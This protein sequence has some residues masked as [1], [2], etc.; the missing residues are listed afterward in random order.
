MARTGR[1]GRGRAEAAKVELAT[2]APAVDLPD[3][4]DASPAITNVVELPVPWDGCGDSRWRRGCA[5]SVG[6]SGGGK[7]IN[8]ADCVPIPISAVPLS[9][10]TGG[11]C[12]HLTPGSSLALRCGLQIPVL[13]LGTRQLKPGSECRDTVRAAL[14]CGYRLID[15][16]STYGNEEDVG[17]GIR[18]AGLQRED[19]FIVTKLAPS[20]HGDLEDVEEALQA[21]LQRLGTTYIDLYLIQSP[22]GGSV[23]STWA[24]ML[25][26]R[27]RG[28]ARVVGVSNFGIAHLQGL[29]GV[30][31]E[32]PEVNQ[33]ELHFGLQQRSLA[34]YC[35][36]MGIVV[37]AAC[38]LARGRLFSGQTS[39]GGLAA[40][41]GR[42]EAELA[43]RWCLQRGYVAIPKT[44][45]ASR[46]EVNAPFGFS[47][48]AAEMTEIDS[49]DRG[50]AASPATK[51]IQLPWE[52]AVHEISEV[53]DGDAGTDN[54][55]RRRRRRRRP[56]GKGKGKA[57][58]RGSGGSSTANQTGTS[59]GNAATRQAAV[60]FGLS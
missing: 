17:N 20:D 22:K 44:K 56:K 50:V 29:S 46:V 2:P 16:A 42:T 28:L 38:P 5:G 23:I 7:V 37:M 35:R 45:D 26:I 27:S 41:R 19:V 31:L 43:L 33:I 53:S 11:T 39:L 8:A 14:R 25:E 40:K 54:V 24:A 10:E 59:S 32:P 18:A 36:T 60:L 48:S 49:L 4:G 57:Q 15:T 6:V 47:L 51:C 52:Q 30:S 55:P 34:S 3:A 1:W 21:S 12:R 13:G 9:A 58:G